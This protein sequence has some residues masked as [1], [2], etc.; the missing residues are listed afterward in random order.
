MEK[1]DKATALN[2]KDNSAFS[3][4]GNA[5]SGLAKLKNDETLYRQSFEKYGKAAALNPKSDVAFNN[6]GNSFLDLAKFKNDEA[7]YQQSI[8]MFNKAVELGG[9]SYNLA[10]AYALTKDAKNALKYL[11]NSL[12]QK[13]I[14]VE[15]VKEDEDWA[16]YKNDVEFTDLLKKYND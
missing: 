14:T 13:E 4:W 5:I 6:W 7:L 2:P 3:N 10:C 11:E 15:F 9:S 16:A 8:E 12:I 1:Y